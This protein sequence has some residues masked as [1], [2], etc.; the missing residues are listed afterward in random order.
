MFGWGLNS[1]PLKGAHLAQVVAMQAHSDIRLLAADHSP[2]TPRNIKAKRPKLN[3]PFQVD[4]VSVANWPL[5]RL[6]AAIIGAPGTPLTLE[7]IFLIQPS[8]PIH[9]LQGQTEMN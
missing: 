6:Q 7:V 1:L 5:S 9:Q 4:G 3:P 2:P 8:R